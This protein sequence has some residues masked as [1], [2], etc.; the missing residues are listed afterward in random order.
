MIFVKM[1]DKK[2]MLLLEEED[3]DYTVFL[4]QQ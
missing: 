3:K 2:K 1:S 4:W